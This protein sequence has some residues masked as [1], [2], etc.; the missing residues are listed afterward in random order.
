MKIMVWTILLKPT[1]WKMVFSLLP[2]TFP[3]FQTWLFVQT[4]FDLFID[5]DNVFFDIE[6]FID[7]L[8]FAGEVIVTTPL[9]PVMQTLGWWSSNSIFVGP[10]GPLLLGSFVVAITYSV[11]IYIVW[12][13]VSGWNYRRGLSLKK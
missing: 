1:R 10:D 9:K 3:L 5:V 12:S 7:V 11:L 6:E 13:L 8:F 2:F 4:T